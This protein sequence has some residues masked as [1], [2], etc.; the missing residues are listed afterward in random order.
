MK[1]YAF[2][3]NSSACSGC[4]TCQVACKDKN[5][6]KP[7]INWRRIYDIQGGAWK[8]ENGAYVSVPFA[9]NLSVSCFNC[10]NPK[11]VNACPTRAIYENENGIVVIDHDLCMGCRYCEWVCPYGALQFDPELKM[12]TKC[13][14]CEDYLVKGQKPSCVDSCPM[15][16]LD[17]GR[18]DEM[19]AKYGT[20]AQVYPLPEP[21]L[22]GPGMIIKPH[23][24]S[25][26]ANPE[27]ATVNFRE[28]L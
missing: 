1:L 23:K 5:D 13:N 10:E 18:Y 14:M 4:K 17:F 27:S 2:Y 12:M 28:D 16:A 19:T 15:R 26:Q 9:Y 21:G 20:L 7:G 25:D 24:D 22:T 8:S 11:C 6:L 3:I